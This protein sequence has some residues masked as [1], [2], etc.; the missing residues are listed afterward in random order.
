[1]FNRP[2]LFP[3]RA[4][5]HGMDVPARR[6]RGA[7]DSANLVRRACAT[8]QVRPAALLIRGGPVGCSTWVVPPSLASCRVRVPA[9]RSRRNFVRF[10]DRSSPSWE[11]GHHFPRPGRPR[12]SISRVCLSFSRLSDR[13]GQ[14]SHWF[15][16]WF[17]LRCKQR[18]RTVERCGGAT[19]RASW[20]LVGSRRRSVGR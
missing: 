15:S 4:R 20:L 9:V 14:R 5:T 10:F 13:D 1:M 19:S 7:L 12:I 18:Q 11:G 6:A 8:D 3:A 16:A 2:R 17:C